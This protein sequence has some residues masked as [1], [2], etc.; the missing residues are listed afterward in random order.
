MSKLILIDGNA[1]MHRAYHALPPLTTKKGEP[2]NAVYGF[3]SM[4]LGLI[5]DI[6]PTHIAVCF[7]RPEKTFRKE[8]YIHYQ[9][10]RPEM[11]DFLSQQITK[12]HDVLE[13]FGIPVYEKAGFEADDVLGTLAKQSI[14][15]KEWK[16]VS[17]KHEK[18]QKSIR[19]S[20]LPLSRSSTLID[21][22]I[23]VTGDRDIFQLINDKVKVYVPVKGLKEGKLYGV[24]EVKQEFDFEP[25]QMVDYKAL[26]GDSSDNY[27]GVA[28]IGPKTARDL[29]TKY[30]T[31]ENVYKHLS[32]IN[33][34]VRNKLEK[35]RE[36]ADLSYEL[37][38]IDTNVPTEID[39]KKM[40][41]W[42]LGS[43]KA[44]GLFMEYG[45]KSLL[46]RLSNSKPEIGQ[47]KVKLKDINSVSE[48]GMLF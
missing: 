32:E 25:K 7:D 42:D 44:V 45:F 34:N 20:T 37:A 5:N 15:V 24:E 41:E 12:M 8:K 40:G 22:V 48:Q 18:N 23:I 16:S 33:P 46:R 14:R 38:T 26:V 4:L 27:P 13:A 35:D 3:V 2:I 10:Q 30:K 36:G 9:S 39:I 28:G 47:E 21:K 31:K 11:D 6:K 17:K 19:T 1:I 43:E 29:L